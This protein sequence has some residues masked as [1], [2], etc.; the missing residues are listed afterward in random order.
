M[1]V[2]YKLAFAIVL[3]MALSGRGFAQSERLSKFLAE[4]MPSTLIVIEGDRWI[5]KDKA[6][7]GVLVHADTRPLTKLMQI[8]EQCDYTVEEYEGAFLLRKRYSDPRELPCVSAEEVITYVQ[9]VLKAATPLFG[10]AEDRDSYSSIHRLLLSLPEEDWK[11]IQTGVLPVTAL[12]AEGRQALDS[13]INQIYHSPL[14]DTGELFIGWSNRFAK[15]YLS[16]RDDGTVDIKCDPGQAFTLFARIEGADK[17]ESDDALLVNAS[18]SSTNLSDILLTLNAQSKE[19]KIFG[20][21]KPLLYTPVSI[22]GI[23][24]ATP[25]R[26]FRCIARLYGYDIIAKGAVGQLSSKRIASNGATNIGMRVAAALPLPLKRTIEGEN[27]RMPA[28]MLLSALVPKLYKETTHTL[29][30]PSLSRL[31]R[32]ALVYQLFSQLAMNIKNGANGPPAYLTDKKAL[33]LKC[34]RVPGRVLVFA[35][36]I[37]QD[38]KQYA[39]PSISTIRDVKRE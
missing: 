26:V 23:A 38:G 5:D 29:P 18:F 2:F 7:L 36:V 8:G 15:A 35:F 1:R 19:G 33:F 37:E 30:V 24:S 10:K 34:K 28:T 12:N 39:G 9:E 17:G 16:L 13:I 11:Q 6:A 20:A 27:Y 22:A 4:E 14:F 21:A 32:T 3:L 25:R 31:Q